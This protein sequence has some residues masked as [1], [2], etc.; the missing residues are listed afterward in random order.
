MRIGGKPRAALF[1]LMRTVLRYRQ[2]TRQA[3]RANADVPPDL[4]VCSVATAMTASGQLRRLW[5][6]DAPAA[7]D[8]NACCT[9]IV[10]P[11]FANRRREHRELPWRLSFAGRTAI[12]SSNKAGRNRTGERV[13]S[14]SRAAGESRVGGDLEMSSVSQI[15]P[16]MTA[17]FLGSLVEAV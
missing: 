13:R 11:H 8:E 7:Y 4:A 5:G 10:R 16:A 1:M 9:R 6:D 2:W 17:A 12:L 15:G 14:R 3:D